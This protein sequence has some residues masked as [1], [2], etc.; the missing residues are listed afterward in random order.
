MWTVLIENCGS[1]EG[2]CLF[3]CFV[4]TLMLGFFVCVRE[5]LGLFK[6]DTLKMVGL[7]EGFFISGNVNFELTVSAFSSNCKC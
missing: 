1:V 4:S 6:L 3:Y 2:R 5:V 7:C